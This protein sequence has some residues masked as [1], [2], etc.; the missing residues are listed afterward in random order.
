MPIHTRRR[1]ILPTGALLTLLI[2][3]VVAPALLSLAVGI[4]ALALW[5]QAFDIVFGILVLCF[6]ATAIAGGV[7]AIAF[8]RRSTRLAEMQTD[9]VA[10]VSHELRTPLA[11]IR[12]LAET[13][14]L[15]RAEEPERRREVLE[16]MLTDVARLE[17]LVERLL[18]WR[19]LDAGKALLEAEPVRVEELVAEVVEPYATPRDGSA[20]RLD[21]RLDPGLPQV[22][23]DRAA[24]GD[25]LRNL[26]DNAVKF[27]G[28][29]GPVEVS[30]RREGREVVLE[31][32]DQGPGIP[33]RERDQVFERFYRV[34]L[35]PRSKQGLGLGLSIA[36]SVIRAHGGRIRVESEPGLGTAVSVRLPVADSKG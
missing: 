15:G 2:G 8:L 18:R 5:R 32:R 33:R 34:N 13:L 17:E 1:P 10:N 36:Q 26:V 11:G 3:L 22:V 21:V 19:R 30:A 25:A 29:R 9:F 6:A 35:H 28:D 4:V 14:E 16:L 12:L 31:V 20:M 24:L 7:T 23:G 27:G